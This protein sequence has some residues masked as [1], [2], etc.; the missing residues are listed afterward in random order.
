MCFNVNA[1]CYQETANVSTACGGLDTG[2]YAWSTGW[3]CDA[4]SFKSMFDGS[5]ATYCYNDGSSKNYFYVNYSIPPVFSSAS[6]YEIIND[7]SYIFYDQTQIPASCWNVSGE[8]NIKLRFS[9]DLTYTNSSCYNGTEWENLRSGVYLSGTIYDE[10]IYWYEPIENIVNCTALKGGNIVWNLTQSIGMPNFSYYPTTD[11]IGME[12]TDDEFGNGQA[13]LIPRANNITINCNGNYILGNYSYANDGFYGTYGIYSSGFNYLSLQNC[14]VM[15]FSTGLHLKNSNF[16]VI[17]YTNFSDSEDY[18]L[19]DLSYF[20]MFLNSQFYNLPVF[21]GYHSLSK[22]NVNELNKNISYYNYSISLRDTS[23]YGSLQFYQADHSLI[24]NITLYSKKYALLSLTETNNFTMINTTLNNGTLFLSST[25]NSNFYNNTLRNSTS[26]SKIELVSSQNNTIYNNLIYGTIRNTKSNNTLVYNNSFFN[27]IYS[28]IYNLNSQNN[29]YFRNYFYQSSSLSNAYL[30][31]FINSGSNLLYNNIFNIS[32]LYY[33]FSGTTNFFNTSYQY[34]VRILTQGVTLGGNFWAYLNGTGYSQ[35]CADT[36]QNGFCDN[37]FTIYSANIDYL[38][39]SSYLETNTPTWTNHSNNAT[40]Y[41]KVNSSVIFMVNLTDDLSGLYSYIFSTNDTGTWVNQ[42]EVLISGT[43]GYYNASL[44][45]SQYHNT[46]LCGK[47]FFFDTNLNA[48]YTNLSCFVVGNTEPVSTIAINKKPLIA[49]V[50]MNISIGYSDVDSDTWLYN[51]TRWW[52][53]SLYL[54]TYDN[55]TEI[56]SGV[57]KD[58]EVW[59]AQAQVFDGTSWSNAVNDSVVIGDNVSPDM[60]N[61]FIDSGTHYTTDDLIIYI[62]VTD[63]SGLFDECYIQYYKSDLIIPTAN[64]TFFDFTGSIPSRQVGLNSFST[65][66]LEL[67]K[68]WCYDVSGNLA[69]NNSLK[70]NVT[71]TTAPVLSSGGGGSAPETKKLCAIEVKP[72]EVF[73]SSS[74]RLAEIKIENKEDF[75][76]D[77][78]FEFMDFNGERSYIKELSVTNDPETIFP[79][80]VKSFGVRYNGDSRETGKNKLILHSVNCN[81]IEI[82]IN[83]NLGTTEAIINELFDPS[84]TFSQNL[85]FLM[86]SP[87]INWSPLSFIPTWGLFLFVVFG[88]SWI[89]YNKLFKDYKT[90][91][92]LRL[93]VSIIFIL[94]TALIITFVLLVASRNLT[95]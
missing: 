13:C 83:T 38:P 26:R 10:G 5:D 25:H 69:T 44:N 15:T 85:I 92:K 62:N 4:G 12:I 64:I 81:D 51:Y 9:T 2:T 68:A 89:V 61:I 65:G 76:Y 20:S 32:K 29:T 46:T 35:N 17:N 31:Y 19:L 49:G 21:F 88:L 57:T 47:F 78:D 45:I 43:S 87:L 14:S 53:G 93:L 63:N 72:L 90:N 16:S 41:S 37:N 59:Y 36:D 55:Y 7:E 18:G 3:S 27:P 50:E 91:N 28:L 40:I 74:S 86:S 66:T 58:G 23:E 79:S 94:F 34:G 73:V 33:S 77:P 30:F 11:L 1:Y 70:I 82:V 67:R 56:P 6:W 42:S 84:K 52:N 48:N 22:N 75:T 24:D 60:Y 54:S 39:Y 71:I 80:I 95:G 8:G